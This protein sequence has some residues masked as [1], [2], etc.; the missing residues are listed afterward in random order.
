ME[1]IRPGVGLKITVFFNDDDDDD[2]DGLEEEHMVEKI[3]KDYEGKRASAKL[4]E[5]YCEENLAWESSSYA[6]EIKTKID[7]PSSFI[8]RTHSHSQIASAS[9]PSHSDIFNQIADEIMSQDNE[10]GYIR[11]KYGHFEQVQNFD[12]RRVYEASVEMNVNEKNDVKRIEQITDDIIFQDCDELSSTKETYGDAI[13]MNGESD[14]KTK[15]GVQE[16]LENE[17]ENRVVKV[18]E[19]EIQD[20]INDYGI[21]STDSQSSTTSNILEADNKTNHI[22]NTSIATIPGDDN[23]QATKK[24]EVVKPRVKKKSLVQT[25]FGLISLKSKSSSGS[26]EVKSYKLKVQV[27][28]GADSRN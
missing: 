22:S 20:C 13:S 11:E 21:L 28:G 25:L 23:V 19:I 12:G 5:E 17:Y 2:K 9:I 10:F 26:Q 7:H 3:L 8:F 15:D 1:D 18:E 24:N 27:Q 6:E 4:R 14:V 16:S